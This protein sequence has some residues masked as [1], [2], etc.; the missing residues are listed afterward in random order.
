MIL[1][2]Q[3]PAPYQ[4]VT[5]GYTIYEG[6]FGGEEY[7]PAWEYTPNGERYETPDRCPNPQQALVL[8]L[9]LVRFYG[10]AYEMPWSNWR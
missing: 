10:M 3:A 9:A 1:V 4:S 6:P 5:L 7:A 8:A 2:K